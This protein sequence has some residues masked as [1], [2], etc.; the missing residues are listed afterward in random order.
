VELELDHRKREQLLRSLAMPHAETSELAE[1]GLL[2]WAD[3]LPAED[4]AGLV[5]NS[6]GKPVR[7]FPGEGWRETTE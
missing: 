4:G 5:D 3:R 6:S 1:A 2:D 7:W